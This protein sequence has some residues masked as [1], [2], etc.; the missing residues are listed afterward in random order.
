MM[1]TRK[2]LAAVLVGALI[3]V[4]TGC[5]RNDTGGV[6]DRP[7]ALQRTLNTG[8]IRAAY[9]VLPP[10]VIKDPNTGELSGIFPDTLRE[11]AR[12]MNLEVQ[13]VE[14]VGWGTMIE[15]LKARRYDVVCTQVWPNASRAP[16]ADFVEPLFY[17]GVGVYVR[18]GDE[19]F[20]R[21]NLHELNDPGVRVSTID[22]EMSDIIAKTDFPRARIVSLPQL[23]DASQVLL[24]VATGKAD[25]TF[26]QTSIADAYLARNPDSIRNIVPETP[27]RVFPNSMM[28]LKNEH[29]LR[30]TL[31]I[32]VRELINGG[33][34]NALIDKYEEFPGSLYR[35]AL[36]FRRHRTD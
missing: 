28:V 13:W 14:E 15:G 5:F 23:S 20:G 27:I 33:F 3:G 29:A 6:Q 24:E 9:V 36:P 25:V 19:R 4:T 30:S 35:R 2:L 7:D 10:S 34:V 11:V 21:G 26:M 22:G 8:K 12:R 17:I 1:K 31:D 16:H 18:A 32:A